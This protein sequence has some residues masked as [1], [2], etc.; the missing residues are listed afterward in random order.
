MAPLIIC[1]MHRSGTSLIC[2]SLEQL[3]L[4]VGQEKEHN[5]EAVFFQMLNQWM[6]EQLGASWD[7]TY[8]MRFLNDEL[9]GY[10]HVVINNVMSSST[11]TTYTGPDPQHRTLFTPG[12]A[13]LWGWKDPRNTF[14]ASIWATLFPG[15]KL[16]HVCRNPL[17]VADSLRRREHEI[18]EYNKTILAQMLP[19]QLDGAMQFQQSPRL[20]HLEEGLALWEEY[21]TRALAL[22]TEFGARALRIRYEDV[23]ADPANE[24]AR[25]ADFAGLAPATEQLATAA[26]QVN[27]DRRC[28]FTRSAELLSAYRDYRH[29]DVMRMLGYDDLDDCA[30]HSAA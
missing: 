4:F 13:I 16:L 17:D 25:I 3:G 20:F 8:N 21:T 27:P 11:A 12:N 26:S 2:R 15:A 7:N 18:L 6:F 22:E 23:L 24:L 9:A 29:R 10:F 1:G 28:A 19:E 14:T 30:S 5:H